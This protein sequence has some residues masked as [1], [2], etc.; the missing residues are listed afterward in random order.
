MGYGVAVWGFRVGWG[1]LGAGVGLRGRSEILVFLFVW[2]C[3]MC[4][5]MME[6]GT[7]VQG[8]RAKP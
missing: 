8:Q 4:L 3:Q 1:C 7:E 6:A 5:K 2:M